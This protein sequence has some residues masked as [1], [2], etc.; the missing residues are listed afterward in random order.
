[1]SIDDF[2]TGH[3]SLNYLKRF[4]ISKLKVDQ[5]FVRDIV[6]DADDA[7]IVQTIIRL[8]HNLHLKVIAEGVESAEQLDFLKNNGCDEIQG[9]YISK[10]LPANDF[11][12]FVKSHELVGS[13]NRPQFLSDRDNHA[14][15]ITEINRQ[16][17]N[18]L[19]LINK[20]NEAIKA[21]T[22]AEI[23]ARIIEEFSASA[24]FHFSAEER[25]M[26][27][28]DYPIRNEH[29]KEHNTLLAEL[30]SIKD[31]FGNRIEIEMVQS[32][33]KWLLSHIESSDQ[34]LVRYIANT[35]S[36]HLSSI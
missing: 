2:G 35:E 1:V 17:L 20:L 12:K 21:G 13:G 29:R 27:Q 9:F 23:L 25:L 36:H 4:P 11:E 15:D 8:G 10:P 3:S 32:I 5:S 7:A 31:M 6:T 33:K 16:H 18:L 22:P 14:T 24:E 30:R 19:G 28:C 34:R 26:K